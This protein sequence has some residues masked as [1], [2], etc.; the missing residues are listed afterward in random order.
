MAALQEEAGPEH[1]LPRSASHACDPA[2]RRRVNVKIVSERLGRASVTNTL[3]TYARHARHSGR[4]R[5]RDQ[6][7]AW[8]GACRVS[9]RTE[10]DDRASIVHASV[11][12]R[13]FTGEEVEAIATACGVTCERAEQPLDWDDRDEDAEGEAFHDGPCQCWRLC[14][15][16]PRGSSMPS[17]PVVCPRAK[18]ERGATV[19]PGRFIAQSNSEQRTA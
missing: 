2:A 9:D 4:G 14:H 15:C 6:R 8:R 10:E 3:G 11:R 19:S 7:G 17:S 5:R 16:S 13:R 1:S 12:C 18:W